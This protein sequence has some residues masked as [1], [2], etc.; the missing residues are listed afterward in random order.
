MASLFKSLANLLKTTGGQ[1]SKPSSGSSA[2]SVGGSIGQ[3]VANGAK[4]AQQ[5]G[6]D[7][8]VLPGLVG[9]LNKNLGNIAGG[10]KDDRVLP[11]TI[12]QAN[13]DV[14]R[15]AA[16]EARRAE[17]ARCAALKVHVEEARA[18]LRRAETLASQARDMKTKAQSCL[19]L[20]ESAW[21]GDSGDR[22]KEAIGNW[23]KIQEN[24]VQ[25]ME[26]KIQSLRKAI[27][28]LVQADEGLANYLR[29]H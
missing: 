23:I 29:S 26:M 17:E 7:G 13:Q 27:D 12:G 1:S 16:E 5:S 10:S 4:A 20:T 18:A 19:T 14:M 24:D 6:D 21:K 3:A 2:G 25:S 8:R 22:M 15:K 9:D 11:G 28:T